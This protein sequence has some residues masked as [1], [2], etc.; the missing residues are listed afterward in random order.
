MTVTSIWLCNRGGQRKTKELTE[1]AAVCAFIF[2]LDGLVYMLKGCLRKM[3]IPRARPGS[4][5]QMPTKNKN[6]DMGEMR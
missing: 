5:K 4:R 1:A 6:E 3:V 2:L